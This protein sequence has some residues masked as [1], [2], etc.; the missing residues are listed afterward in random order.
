MASLKKSFFLDPFPYLTCLFCS[1]NNAFD[2]CILYI[3][4]ADFTYLTQF[5]L[6]QPKEKSE[7]EE[8][9]E[10]NNETGVKSDLWRK[11]LAIQLQNIMCSV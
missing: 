6:L 4:H 3:H 5:F 11:S 8:D 9:G 7:K 10:A 2:D 1:D